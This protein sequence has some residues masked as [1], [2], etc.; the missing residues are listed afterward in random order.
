MQ[1]FWRL[2]QAL[3]EADAVR[4]P[5][6]IPLDPDTP[7]W[8]FCFGGIP[9][10][11]NVNTPAHLRR[12]SRNLGNSVV[13]VIQPREAIDFVAAPDSSGDRHRNTI[14]HRIAGYDD[15]PPSPDLATYGSATNRDWK[16]YFLTDDEQGVQGSCPFRPM[17]KQKK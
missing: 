9:L 16:L 10:F 13:L 8:S 12:H 14:R 7:T 3:H 6:E 4:W 11:V 15:V 5:G 1:Q 2:L 17:S